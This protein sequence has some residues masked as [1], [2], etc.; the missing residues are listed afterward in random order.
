MLTSDIFLISMLTIIH[1]GFIIIPKSILKILTIILILF[2]SLSVVS[3]SELSDSEDDSLDSVDNVISADDSKTVDDDMLDS[4]D[5][6]ASSSDK[7]SSDDSKNDDDSSEDSPDCNL[8]FTKE[9]DKKVNVGDEVEWNITVE[10]TLNIAYNVS[11]EEKLP[12]NFE[13]V[14]VKASKGTYDEEMD[15]WKIGDL[16]KLESA[17]LTIKAKATKAGNFTNKAD[18]FTDSNNL[19]ENT[20]VQADVEVVSEDKSSAVVEDSE[21]KKETNEVENP[22]DENKENQTITNNTNQTNSTIVDLENAGNP[23]MVLII[24]IL[25]VFGL[26]ILKK[27]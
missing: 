13:L 27:Q 26:G 3:T 21:D 9:G 5:E 6:K 24:S 16:K 4:D 15:I 1:G 17:N 23:I 18:I 8:T 25:I 7:I 20:T 19:N 14:S 2:L 12:E 10:N 22:K 11:V